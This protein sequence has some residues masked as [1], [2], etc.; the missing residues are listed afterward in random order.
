MSRITKSEDRHY[1]A[2]G[3]LL[4]RYGVSDPSAGRSAGSYAFP[5]IQKVYD[6]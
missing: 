3:V 5:E 6:T 1:D 4:D 2:V